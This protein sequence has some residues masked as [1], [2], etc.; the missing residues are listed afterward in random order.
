MDHHKQ[1]V[2]DPAL[3]YNSITNLEV[4]HGPE[5]FSH[6]HHLG[7]HGHLVCPVSRDQ[8]RNHEVHRAGIEV[9]RDSLESRTVP[10]GHPVRGPSSGDHD[11]TR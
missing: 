2:S 7:L 9:G 1:S 8:A 4:K 11:G 5:A 10:E 6:S 3:V